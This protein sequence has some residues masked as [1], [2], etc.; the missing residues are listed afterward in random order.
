MS[1]T[2]EGGWGQSLG[3][4]HNL[5]TGTRLFAVGTVSSK[6]KPDDPATYTTIVTGYVFSIPS[7][8]PSSTKKPAPTPSAAPSR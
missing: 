3:F 6:Q 5:Q 1:I 4:V 2:V 7:T 8:T